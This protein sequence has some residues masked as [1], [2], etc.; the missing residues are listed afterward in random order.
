MCVCLYLYIHWTPT[1][2]NALYQAMI[3]GRIQILV[4]CPRNYNFNS[5]FITQIHNIYICICNPRETIYVYMCVASKYCYTCF[6]ARTLALR[7]TVQVLRGT[8]YIDYK[9]YYTLNK[10]MNQLSSWQN[11]MIIKHEHTHIYSSLFFQLQLK[12]MLD[13]DE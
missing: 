13:N 10:S 9:R 7:V 11:L 4:V 12:H 2:I 6:H 3:N 8:G 1:H 5:W